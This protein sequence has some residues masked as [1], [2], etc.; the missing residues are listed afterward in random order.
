L[1]SGAKNVAF[2]R[3]AVCSGLPYRGSLSG[4]ADALGH[5]D[6]VLR[7]LLC[8]GFTSFG[9]GLVVDTLHSI[10]NWFATA[11]RFAHLTPSAQAGVFLEEVLETCKALGIEPTAEAAA[12][13]K[14]G[15]LQLKDI[16][17]KETL[18]GLCD[19]TVTAVGLAHL[20]GM[21]Y[22]GGLKEVDRSNWSKF[23]DGVPV[24]KGLK[25]SKGKDYTPPNLEDYV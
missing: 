12:A 19:T 17:R 1:L 9:Y 25:I 4:D 6:S 23:E 15:E 10:Q 16:D 5:R 3:L 24:M 2:H 18:D 8:L 22:R 11:E 21:D 14:S 20:L 13:L 7:P